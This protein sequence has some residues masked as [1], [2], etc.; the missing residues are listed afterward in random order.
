[1]AEDTQYVLHMLRH[2][3]ASRLAQ[4]GAP[5]QMIQRW[6]G[7]KTIT[8]TMRYMHLAPSSLDALTAL[9]ERPLPGETYGRGH[10]RSMEGGQS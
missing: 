1:M 8:V 4:R 2:T 7:H 10:L 3:C 9:L 6:M 5:P